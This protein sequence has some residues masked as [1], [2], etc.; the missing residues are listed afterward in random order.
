MYV[1]KIKIKQNNPKAKQIFSNR[2]QRTRKTTIR[3][4]QQSPRRGLMN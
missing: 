4:P 3:S 1:V 2:I